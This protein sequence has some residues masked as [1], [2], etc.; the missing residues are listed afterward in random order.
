M[1]DFV[2]APGR[3]NLIGEHIDY[4]DLPVLPVAMRRAI[5]AE[6]RPRADRMIRAEGN[7][8][9]WSE[10][11]IERMLPEIAVEPLDIQGRRWI[12]ID[13]YDDLAEAER[14]FSVSTV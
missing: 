4:H 6:F 11:A 12:E 10:V 14:L 8:N 5:R 3:V 13:N 2:I 1:S 7:R 9:L